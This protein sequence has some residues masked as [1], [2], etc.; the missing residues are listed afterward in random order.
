[1]ESIQLNVRRQSASG[2]NCT[3]TTGLEKR[4]RELD[5]IVSTAGSQYGI[6]VS[7][8]RPLDFWNYKK[9]EYTPG[10]LILSSLLNASTSELWVNINSAFSR[11]GFTSK[12]EITAEGLFDK[13]QQIKQKHTAQTHIR[14]ASATL[15]E[16]GDKP[17]P[18]AS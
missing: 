5:R 2:K 12:D 14:E 1:M 15:H 4:G 11:G 18:I 16:Q 9:I 6:A 7:R 10:T 3:L 17:T 13:L 8:T